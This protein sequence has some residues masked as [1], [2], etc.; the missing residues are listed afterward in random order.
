MDK[1]KPRWNPAAALALLMLPLL[2]GA[3]EREPAIPDMGSWWF[4]IGLGE[5]LLH[6][7]SGGGGGSTLNLGTGWVISPQWALGLELGYT[8]NRNGCE[9][10]ECD[11]FGPDVSYSALVAEYIPAS[12]SWRPRVAAG[13]FEYCTAIWWYACETAMGPGVGMYVTR[14]WPLSQRKVWSLGLRVGAEVAYFPAK[15]A[16]G[17]PA[18]WHSAALLSVQLKRN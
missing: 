1:S 14:Q 18:F 13:I 12:S 5:S 16:A 9:L 6:S 7:A 10:N 8:S 17:A 15:R 3:A 4:E 11:D 2:A